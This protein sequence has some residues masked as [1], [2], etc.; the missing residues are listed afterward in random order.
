MNKR[1]FI[2]LFLC[3]FLSTIAQSV[4]AQFTISGI[5]KDKNDNLP[6]PQVSIRLLSA[7]DS[8]FVTGFPA[9][10]TEHFL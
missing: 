5:V 2:A 10:T 8:T 4:A 7:K 3:I 6:L 1:G 9:K